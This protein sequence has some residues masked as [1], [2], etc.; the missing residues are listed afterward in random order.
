MEGSE[1]CP[2]FPWV[3]EGSQESGYVQP[4]VANEGHAPSK[5]V[6]GLMVYIGLYHPTQLNEDYNK[7]LCP[8]PY[9]TTSIMESKAVFFFF[10]AQ[11]LWWL[12]SSVQELVM[13]GFPAAP[14]LILDSDE[15]DVVI[16]SERPAPPWLEEKPVLQKHVI[17]L[18]AE[19]R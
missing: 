6:L 13:P 12:F 9:E 4:C 18:M 2:P 1:D 7:P 16:L 11:L 5:I 14:T 3:F 15:E 10:V 8:D 17:L 19:I